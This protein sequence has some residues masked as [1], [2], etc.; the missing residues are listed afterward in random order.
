MNYETVL[1][2]GFLALVEELAKIFFDLLMKN[3]RHEMFI[4]L[5]WELC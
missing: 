4:L 5:Y 3:V 2:Q 1:H